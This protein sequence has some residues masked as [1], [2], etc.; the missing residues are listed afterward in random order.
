[1]TPDEISNLIVAGAIFVLL[2]A[3]LVMAQREK[4]KEREALANAMLKAY[5]KGELD[6][7]IDGLEREML[8]KR[9]GSWPL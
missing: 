8:A 2:V 5:D 9:P 4:R 7:M 6:R 3:A 1:V